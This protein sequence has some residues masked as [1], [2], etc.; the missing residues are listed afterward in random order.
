MSPTQHW[1][2][3]D[4]NDLSSIEYS[5]DW[6][7]DGSGGRLAP[8]DLY[9]ATAHGTN[10][11]AGLS[12]RYEGPLP[13]LSS[14]PPIEPCIQAALSR[15]GDRRL[16][17]RMT[18]SRYHVRSTASRLLSRPMSSQKPSITT[19]YATRRLVY[20]S[21]DMKSCSISPRAQN[22]SFGSTPFRSTQCRTRT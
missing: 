9:H 12:F 6:F 21:D 15:F 22:S 4:D 2:Q 1:M 16:Q 14:L 5:G 13:K 8:G 3:V 20:R 7:M 11:K 10:S 17:F 18:G 19:A